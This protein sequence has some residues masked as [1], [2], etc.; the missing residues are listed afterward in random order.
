MSADVVVSTAHHEFFGISV[1]EAIYAGAFPV[2]PN[3]LVYPE[4]VPEHLHARC[5]YDDDQDLVDKLEWAVAH[6][7]ARREVA[8]AMRPLMADADWGTVARRYDQ[9]F[10]PA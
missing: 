10:L 1:T 8:E 7:G 9:A 3:R 4:R 5:L 6:D 2:L